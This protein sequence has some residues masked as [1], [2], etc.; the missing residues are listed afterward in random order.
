[1]K[2]L[3]LAAE[4]CRESLTLEFST[5]SPVDGGSYEE[6]RIALSAQQAALVIDFCLAFLR[7]SPFM[8]EGDSTHT[9]EPGTTWMGR[10][11]TLSED[12]ENLKHALG[13]RDDQRA[14]RR[15]YRNH[16]ATDGDN[17][18]MARLERAGLMRRGREYAP[19][20]FYFYAT[21]AGCREAGLTD[22]QSINAVRPPQSRGRHQQ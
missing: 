5:G 13:A 21:L 4:W 19:G 18:S 12:L 7:E 1:M 9:V 15:G 14:D 20:K 10:P 11:R 16:F 3:S 8:G 6:C 2:P 17:P 22:E